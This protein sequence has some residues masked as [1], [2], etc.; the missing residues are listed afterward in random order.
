VG[1]G[2][3]TGT[4]ER[5]PSKNPELSGQIPYSGIRGVYQSELDPWKDEGMRT[6][7]QSYYEALGSFLAHQTSPWKVTRAFLWNSD[8]W[9]VE[10][11]YLDVYRDPVIV[12]FLKDN[13]N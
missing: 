6:Y 8:S 11:I 13:R 5:T 1:L 9:D 2:G 12:S 3:G 10:G 7:R 4:N